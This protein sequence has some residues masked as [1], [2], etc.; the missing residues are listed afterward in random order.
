M[1]CLLY[2]WP[3]LFYAALMGFCLGAMITAS[4]AIR[5]WLARQ[6]TEELEERDATLSRR[7]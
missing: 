1:A 3:L 2:E 7:D 5:V 6:M 4:L